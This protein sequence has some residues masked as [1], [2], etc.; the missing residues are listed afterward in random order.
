LCLI[1][2][3]L[4]RHMGG[5]DIVARVGGGDE[6][7]L[8]LP[9]TEAAPAQRILSALKSQLVE[10]TEQRG[11]PVTFSIGAVTF[12]Q[13][14]DPVDDMIRCA[15]R[16]MYAAK[17]GGKNVIQHEVFRNPIREEHSVN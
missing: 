9:G 2:S 17:N 10:E 6:F 1:A 7:A 11:W 8:L 14:P 12:V 15:D 3:T 4:Q 13:P 5:S 16:L